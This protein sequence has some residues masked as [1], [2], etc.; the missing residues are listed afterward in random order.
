MKSPP[1][2]AGF[3]FCGMGHRRCIVTSYWDTKGMPAGTKVLV[4][5]R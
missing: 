1:G 4:A 5:I 3:S 2:K